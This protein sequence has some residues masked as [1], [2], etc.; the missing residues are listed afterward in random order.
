[1]P[2]MDGINAL[3]EI[4]KWEEENIIEYWG[5][6]EKMSSILSLATVIVLPSY[7]E[8]FPKVLMEAAA[9]GRPTVTTDTPGCRDAIIPNKT[10]YLAKNKD[11][12]DLAKKIEML[13]LD[14]KKLFEFSQN[15]ISYA[16][17]NFDILQVNKKHFEIYN[18]FI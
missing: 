5:H 14:Q 1:M 7:R 11:H 2:V 13:I 8:G 6:K 15:S 10:G 17:K 12:K 16:F 18:I 4:R 3:R 9:C